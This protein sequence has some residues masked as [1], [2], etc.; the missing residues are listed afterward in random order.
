VL[1]IFTCTLLNARHRKCFRWSLFKLAHLNLA[2]TRSEVASDGIH[3][4]GYD[5]YI[6]VVF[7]ERWEMHR[8]QADLLIQLSRTNSNKRPRIIAAMEPEISLGVLEVAV[9]GIS[10]STVPHTDK[11]KNILQWDYQHDIDCALT[12]N[13]P[14]CDICSDAG[15]ASIY[16]P[17][18]VPLTVETAARMLENPNSEFF[19]DKNPEKAHIKDKASSS[20]VEDKDD[21]NFLYLSRVIHEAFDGIN[22]KPKN[23]PWFVVHYVSH[24]ELSIDCRSLQNLF[25][26]ELQPGDSV[27][28]Y[29]R[30]EVYIE[31]Y[32]DQKADLYSK[33]LRNGSHKVSPDDVKTWRLDLYFNDP[34]K[35]KN[36]F[37]WKE[38]KT[39]SIWDNINI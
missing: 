17:E 8:F 25:E 2:M 20:A 36:Y 32:S 15:S 37:D 9:V 26:T 10:L 7:A 33:Y 13:S 38:K 31:F 11:V 19:V 18:T 3:T 30:V 34:T 27:K 12:D 5:I 14:P 24:D 1:Y 16:E 39:R 4:N 6:S 22:T 21:N 23:F 35:A 28:R 29:H